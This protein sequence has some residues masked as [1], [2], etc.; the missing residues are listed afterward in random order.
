MGESNH[1]VQ[2]REEMSW[3]AAQTRRGTKGLRTMYSSGIGVMTPS[4]IAACCNTVH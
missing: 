4:N 2:M 1:K 3:N